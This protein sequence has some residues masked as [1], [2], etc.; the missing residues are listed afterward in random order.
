MNLAQAMSL[1]V[2]PV[3]DLKRRSQLRADG[4]TTMPFT[5]VALREDRVLCVVSGPRMAAILACADTLAIGLAPQMLVA[6]G[7]VTLPERPES[8]DVPAQA[9]GLGIAYTSMSRELEAAL[10]V[11][12]FEVVGDR[13]VRFGPP[14]KGAPDDKAIMDHL[15]VAMAKAPLDPAR[16]A[17]KDEAGTAGQAADPETT[18]DQTTEPADPPNFLPVGQ[19]R[20]AIDAGTATTA[21]RKVAGIGGTVLMVASSPEHATRL[22]AYGLPEK[23]LLS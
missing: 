11:Q 2:Q 9:A 23:L 12:R 3:Q 20:L 16:V 18:P 7:Q 13:E 4:E 22:L 14:A 5:L 10:A 6:A 17:R 15:A 21:H 8:S 1:V 19:G